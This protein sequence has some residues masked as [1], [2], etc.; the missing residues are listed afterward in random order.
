MNFIALK[1][2][3]VGQLIRCCVDRNRQIQFSQDRH[4][5]LVELS[6]AL[7]TEQHFAAR[8]VG[9]RKQEL[10]IDEIRSEEHTSE[11]QSP[12]YLVCGLLLEK[13]TASV[14]SGSL[15]AGQRFANP[16]LPGFNSNSSEQ[17][18]FND[19]A[20]T[21]IYPLSLHDALPI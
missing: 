16:G 6:D 4:E 21:E 3:G 10:V 18:V 14:A 8:A 11:L 17:T 5:R 13:I 15:Q 20:T 1:W 9:C 12:M 7:G 2:N 19:T